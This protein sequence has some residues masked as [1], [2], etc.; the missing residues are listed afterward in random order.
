MLW[1]REKFLASARNRILIPWSPNLQPIYTR[2]PVIE[3][4]KLWDIPSGELEG[5]FFPERDGQNLEPMENRVR[6]SASR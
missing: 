6:N 2:R 3:Q 1:R 5:Q 4:N